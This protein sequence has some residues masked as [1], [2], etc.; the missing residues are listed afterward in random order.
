[1]DETK[2]DPNGDKQLWKTRANTGNKDQSNRTN[3][4]FQPMDK[5][6][7]DTM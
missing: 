1:M 7:Y 4:L 3:I 6:M 5:V 2:K